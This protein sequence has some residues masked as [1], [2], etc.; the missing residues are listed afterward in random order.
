MVEDEKCRMVRPDSRTRLVFPHR[1]GREN[2]V[3]DGGDRWCVEKT[4]YDLNRDRGV[5][6]ARPSKMAFLDFRTMTRREMRE[7]IIFVGLFV[8]LFETLSSSLERWFR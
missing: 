3:D 4:I 8:W 7:K 5:I 2:P 1:H 6:K